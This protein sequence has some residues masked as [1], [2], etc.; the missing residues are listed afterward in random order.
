MWAVVGAA[1]A[2]A[3]VAETSG[4][5]LLLGGVWEVVWGGKKH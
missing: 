1:A 3:D 4:A 5:T 2:W